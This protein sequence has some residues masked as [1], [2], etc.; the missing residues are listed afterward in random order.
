LVTDSETA[1]AEQPLPRRRVH[2]VGRKLARL[3]DAGSALR[4]D[5]AR[6]L[7]DLLLERFLFGGEFKNHKKKPRRTLSTPRS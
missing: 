2:H 1:T 6:E 4:D 5:L 7:L 3:V